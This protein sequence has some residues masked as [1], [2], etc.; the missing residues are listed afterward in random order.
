VPA[1]WLTFAEGA[2][3]SAYDIPE[4]MGGI[5]VTTD[6]QMAGLLMKLVAGGFLW[7]VIAFRFFQWAARFSDTDRATDQA[8]PVHDLTWE[9]VE[10]EFERHPAPAEP[11]EPTGT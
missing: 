5:D 10:A 7:M 6:Q 4:R 2:V 9:Q 11:A 1:G 3:Y 8:G